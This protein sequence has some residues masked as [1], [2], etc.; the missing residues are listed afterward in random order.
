[1]I[2]VFELG[3]NISKP[4][5]FLLLFK[6]WATCRQNFPIFHAGK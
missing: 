2:F 1:M 4:A 6:I 3:R 5:L